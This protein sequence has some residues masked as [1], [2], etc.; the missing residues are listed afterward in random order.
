MVNATASLRST[1]TPD[2]HE[3]NAAVSVA[4]GIPD[5]LVSHNTS[6][7]IVVINSP[8]PQD[9]SSDNRKTSRGSQNKKTHARSKR[10]ST[11][12]NGRCVDDVDLQVSAALKIQSVARRRLSRKSPRKKISG[13]RKKND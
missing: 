10:V 1:G 12:K 13:A 3:A 5:G 4:E 11:P 7:S 6:A 8:R 2:E 9:V